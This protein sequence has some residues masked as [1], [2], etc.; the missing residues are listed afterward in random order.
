MLGGCGQCGGVQK[1]QVERRRGE[2][3]GARCIASYI[4]SYTTDARIYQRIF[5]DTIPV[6][7]FTFAFSISN[8]R[9]TD[10]LL[11]IAAPIFYLGH[12]F[13]PHLRN[14]FEMGTDNGEKSLSK[15]DKIIKIIIASVSCFSNLMTVDARCFSSKYF[16]S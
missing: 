4:S 9:V 13:P 7:P 12:A 6:S 15:H 16:E 2:T 8:P 1:G 10:T 3:E 5:T 14:S 11:A